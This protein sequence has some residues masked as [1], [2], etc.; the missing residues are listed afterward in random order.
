[1]ATTFQYF[2]K[3]TFVPEKNYFSTEKVK[4]ER[5]RTDIED[6]LY[7][8]SDKWNTI[9]FSCITLG[10]LIGFILALIF[11]TIAGLAQQELWYIGTGFGIFLIMGGIIFAN[12]ICWPK[13]Q[14]YLEKLR[15]YR[16]EHEEELWAEATT[17]LKAYNEEQKKIAE[18]WRA[19]HPLE[20]KIR[21]CVK[22]PYSSVDIANLARYYAEV[23]LKEK[24]NEDLG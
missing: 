12:A 14:K 23:Y 1:M 2:D 22:D 17:E 4:R 13:E 19:A 3:D 9:G 16:Y 15:E 5:Q 7:M 21:A 24:D 8:Q 11:A 20:E 10:C 18:T 6:R